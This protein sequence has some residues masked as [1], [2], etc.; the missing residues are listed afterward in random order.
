MFLDN[1]YLAGTDFILS[2]YHDFD[3]I[4]SGGWSLADEGREDGGCCFL[5]VHG[6]WIEVKR[7]GGIRRTS[8]TRSR[9]KA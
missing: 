7:E 5:Q 2:M 9:R 4:V 3:D 1:P 8:G 6:S